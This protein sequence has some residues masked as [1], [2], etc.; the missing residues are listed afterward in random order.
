[1]ISFQ[2]EYSN[3]QGWQRFVMNV[4]P[5]NISAC[6]GVGIP[7]VNERGSQPSGL[8]WRKITL[9]TSSHLPA[10][11]GLVDEQVRRRGL[12]WEI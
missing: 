8:V 7:L 6:E 11:H 9:E 12:R 5:V 10:L 4:A 2:R 3:D 1:M